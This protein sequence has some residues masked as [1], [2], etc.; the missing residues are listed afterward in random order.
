MALIFLLVLVG[1][2]LISLYYYR[3]MTQEEYREIAELLGSVK[4][5]YPEFAE[6]GWISALRQ[7]GAYEEGAALLARY[8]ILQGENVGHGWKVIYLSWFRG[9]NLVL[10]CGSIGVAVTFGFYLRGRRKKL[11]TLAA[12][13]RRVQQGQ[14]AL[15][16]MDN[17]EDELSVLKKELYTVTVMLKESAELSQKQRKALAD[18]VSDI[19]HQ[20]KTP[21]TSCMVLLDNLS[22]SEH[23]DKALRQRFLQEITFQLTNVSWLVATLLKLSR[24]DAGVVEFSYEDF[25]LDE[26]LQGVAEKLEIMAECKQVRIRIVGLP[27]IRLTGDSFW[28]GEAI[29]NIVKNAIEHSPEQEEIL[30]D[31]T[32][33][34]VYTAISIRDHGEGMDEEEQRHIFERFYRNPRAGEENTGIGLALAKEII[35][36]QR[37]YLTVSSSPGAGTEFI[38]KILK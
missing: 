23:M 14:Y 37:G 2:N 15:E 16:L 19:S 9:M 34:N 24:L 10:L 27:G 4:E 6:E 36:Q 1:G 17:T 30:I 20:L 25:S 29:S 13:V 5:Q 38:V 8:G 11:D 12:Y 21:L 26:L 3:Q 32:D 33:T 28:L 7:D 31:R 35:E 18:S 22:E